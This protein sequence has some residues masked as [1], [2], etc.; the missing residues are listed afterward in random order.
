MALAATVL[1]DTGFLAALFRRRDTHRAWAVRHAAE[2]QRPW[3]C[4]EA[5]LAEALFLLG[6]PARPV[7]STLLQRRSLQVSFSFA[8]HQEQ[9]LALMEKYAD[10]PMSLADACLVRMTEVLPDPVVLTTDT[11]FR[12]YRRHGRQVIPCVVPP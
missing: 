11:D 1:V 6:K 4:C 5:V 3:H 7:L 10:V 8:D 2:V 9:V 12:V